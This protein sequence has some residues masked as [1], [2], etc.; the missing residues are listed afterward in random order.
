MDVKQMI[1]Q[2]VLLS[3]SEG[4]RGRKLDE[5]FMDEPPAASDDKYL[6][7]P[8]DELS[9]LMS[10]AFTAG[11]ASRWMY[12]SE[13]YL[14]QTTLAEISIHSRTYELMNP[15]FREVSP[16]VHPDPVSVVTE[17]YNRAKAEIAPSAT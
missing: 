4:T 16:L 12:L 2:H 17:A 7:M 8:R 11:D 3:I 13:R 15:V 9:T 1:T 10:Q 14:D 5:S 6:E